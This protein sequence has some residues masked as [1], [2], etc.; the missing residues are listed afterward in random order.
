MRQRYGKPSK[1]DWTLAAGAL[2][3]GLLLLLPFVPALLREKLPVVL[4]PVGVGLLVMNAFSLAYYKSLPEEEQKERSRAD[5]DERNDMIRGEA[6]W[7]VLDLGTGLW[8]VLLFVYGLYQEN[9]DIFTLLIWVNLF[10]I[11]AIGLTRWWV[12]RKY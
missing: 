10:R 11:C 6:A 4:I 1:W 7:G 9:R 12:S 5:R 2:L 3:A 8:V